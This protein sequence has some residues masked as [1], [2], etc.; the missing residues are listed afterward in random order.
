[1]LLTRAVVDALLF[2]TFSRI[3]VMTNG[4][5]EPAAGTGNSER[6]LKTH[7]IYGALDKC[8]LFEFQ[9]RL[10][11]LPQSQKPV[12]HLIFRRFPLCTRDNL[13][14]LLFVS[15]MFQAAQKVN[16]AVK[17]LN[18]SKCPCRFEHLSS[19][20]LYSSSFLRRQFF[21]R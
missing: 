10:V 6:L 13:V 14:L 18:G 9:L 3:K 7:F 2:W 4:V 21:S 1:M 11:M 20:L 17:K 15:E 5:V 8:A 16:P 12:R 19:H